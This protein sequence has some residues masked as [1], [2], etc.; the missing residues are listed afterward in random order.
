LLEI[1][2][3][4]LDFSKIEANKLTIESI[5]FSL[6]ILL[7][8]LESIVRFK[9]E[10]KG[11]DLKFTID[12][13]VPEFLYGDPTRIRQVLLNFLGNAVKFT[14]RGGIYLSTKNINFEDDK[15]EIKFLIR[16]TGIG[17]NKN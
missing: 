15:F 4:I 8:N 3:D 7:S 11:L 16:D 13:S 5:P 6:K 10:E 1:I 17:I 2:N 9:T 14:E 12:N